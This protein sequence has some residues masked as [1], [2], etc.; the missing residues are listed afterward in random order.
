MD[1]KARNIGINVKPPKE[2]C[3]DS[4][5]PFHGDTRIRGRIF[6]GTLVKKDTHRTAT[7]EWTYSVD[8]PK[9]ERRTMRRTKIR[10]HNPACINAEEGEIVKIAQ[11]RPLSKTKNFIIVEKLGESKDFEERMEAEEESKEVIGKKER[12]K[13]P[14]SDQQERSG[15]NQE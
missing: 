4:K 14:E 12:K 2:T 1:K 10:V 9:Y 15:E 11:T 5:C 6:T 8:V 13:E 3:E 7:V